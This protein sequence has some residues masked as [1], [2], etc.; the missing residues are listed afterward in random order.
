MDNNT[1]E[2]F[3]NEEFGELR[4][5]EIEG[6]PWFVGKDIATVLGYSNPSKALI[7]H[8]DN[9]D[10]LNNVS[11]LSLGQ[12]GGW[13]INESGLYSLILSSKLPSAK[14]FKSWVTREVLPSIRKTGTYA[15]RK[16]PT[17]FEIDE[18]E[19]K[20]QDLIAHKVEL[21]M[22]LADRSNIPEFKQVADIYA[23]NTL[24]GKEVVTLPV[25]EKKTY[26]ATEIADILG[27]SANKVGKIANQHD[28][29]TSEYGKWFYDK[30]KYSNKEVET[31]RYYDKA[32]DALK[33]YI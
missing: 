15:V 26:S 3:K 24:A 1:L 23:A 14:K 27:I 28:L 22:K 29:K 17:Q 25:V 18:L 2:I 16:E 11:L 32:I 10:K 12:R 13:L 31:F 4:V 6:E 20:K 21:W 33:M 9:E 5:V 19:F 30:S 8:V 7:D